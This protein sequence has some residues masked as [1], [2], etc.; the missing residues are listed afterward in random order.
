MATL[1]FVSHDGRATTLGVP[2]GTSVMLAAVGHGVPGITADCNGY[3]LCAT[4]HVFV[5]HPGLPPMDEAEDSLLDGTAVP[6]RADSRLA[7][8]IRMAPALDGLV[9][10]LPERQA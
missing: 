10:R 8:Q 5:D 2:D 9:V 7:C 6:R 4:C 1:T 3:A